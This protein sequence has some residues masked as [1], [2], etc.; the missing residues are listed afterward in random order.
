MGLV[1]KT[2]CVGEGGR[3]KVCP[4]IPGILQE[5]PQASLSQ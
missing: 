4:H 5:P 2:G 3:I 1:D